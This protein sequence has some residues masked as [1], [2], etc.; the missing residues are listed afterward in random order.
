[1]PVVRRAIGK[2]RVR[3]DADRDADLDRIAVGQIDAA[4]LDEAAQRFGARIR[5]LERGT[6]EGDEEAVFAPARGKVVRAAECTHAARELTQHAVADFVTVQIV[7]RV[8][9]VD[10]DKQERLACA[11]CRV[12]RSRGEA[13]DRRAAVGQV[14]ERIDA[15]ALVLR[16]ERAERDRIGLLERIECLLRVVHAG[17]DGGE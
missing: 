1:M 5:F 8:E 7:D 14:R 4:F 6:A 2:E 12:G 10:G 15:V 17:V 3:G 16:L 11:G 9:F 13:R